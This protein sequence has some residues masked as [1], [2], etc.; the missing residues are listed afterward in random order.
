MT[1]TAS[2]TPTRA[3]K[4]GRV[5]T[6]LVVAAAATQ[7]S[8]APATASIVYNINRTITSANPTGNPLQSNTVVGTVTTDG[9]LGVLS[10]ANILSWNLSL[11]DLLNAANNYVLTT[12]N[13]TMPSFSGNSLTASATGLSFNFGGVGEV[14]F[15]ATNPG[16]FSGFRY[17]CLSTGVFACLAGET[18]APNNVF[19]DGTISTGASGPIGNQPLDSGPPNPSVPEP[20]TLALLGLGLA[21]LGIRFRGRQA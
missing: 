9:T 10:Q 1:T 4:T 14:L 17:Y 13:S 21:A 3:T 19:T 16:A 11:T 18:I 5:A 15:Q 2:S 8:A 6:L 7:F 12:A 20:A